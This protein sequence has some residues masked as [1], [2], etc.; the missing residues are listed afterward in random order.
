MELAENVVFAMALAT[1]IT[2]FTTIPMATFTR[3]ERPVGDARAK[4]VFQRESAQVVQ[5]LEL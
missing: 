5:E 1:A 2:Y 4:V 3:Q